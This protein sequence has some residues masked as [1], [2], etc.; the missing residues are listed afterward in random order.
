[1]FFAFLLD[2]ALFSDESSQVV[3]V[4]VVGS[5]SSSMAIL[6]SSSISGVSFVPA[7]IEKA[8]AGRLNRAVGNRD[9]LSDFTY[10]S[11]LIDAVS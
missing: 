9:K 11:N 8:R 1:M 6:D 7:I 10:V 2:S 5:L 4:V 3:Y